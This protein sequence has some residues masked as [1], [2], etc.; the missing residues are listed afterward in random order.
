MPFCAYYLWVDSLVTPLHEV[1]QSRLARTTISVSVGQQV[2]SVILI[3]TQ[4]IV[5]PYEQSPEADYSSVNDLWSSA[6][7]R[8]SSA[9]R[10]DRNEVWRDCLPSCPKT[11]EN[12]DRNCTVNRWRCR[13]GCDCQDGYAR[14]SAASG[15]ISER[16]CSGKSTNLK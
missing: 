15:C 3:C 9:Q 14:L 1:E 12:L 6:G 5:D 7:Q 2:S 10:C 13:S 4:S 16:R 8:P 11:C